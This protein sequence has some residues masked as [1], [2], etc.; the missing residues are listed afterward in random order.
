MDHLNFTRPDIGTPREREATSLIVR[1]ERGELSDRELATEA[2]SLSRAL[3]IPIEHL[4]L[5]RELIRRAINGGRFSL[6]AH[7][8]LSTR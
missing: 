8:Q 1:F 6:A 5:P 7:L 3:G 4:P 2:E